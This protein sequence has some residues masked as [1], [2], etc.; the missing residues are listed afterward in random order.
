MRWLLLTALIT[1]FLGV[2]YTIEP[3]ALGGASQ[4]QNIQASSLQAALK[5]RPPDFRA[6]AGLV[7]F[8]DKSYPVF[9]LN[10]DQRWPMASL[11]KLMTAVIAYDNLTVG[12][13]VKNLVKQIMT[14]SS[15]T[16]AQELSQALGEKEFINAMQAKA[17]ELQMFET[18]YVDPTG[19]SFLNQSTMNDLEKLVRY[20]YKKHPQIF[21]YSRERGSIH[22]LAGE[23][24]FLGGKT[25]LT[26]EAGGNLVSLL[27]HDGRSL[28]IIVLGAGNNPDDRFIQ[29][30]KLYDY[31]INSGN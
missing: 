15:N 30:K 7:K 24:D 21:A 2:S 6:V 17:H 26:D 16:A 23:P 13:K 25:G 3:R 5:A 31:V 18:S 29:T 19:L 22:Q 12:P 14:A 8:L 10:A 1:I 4:D 9:Q 27:N 20:I 11:T 28:L